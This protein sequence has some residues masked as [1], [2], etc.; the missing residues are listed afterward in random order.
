[1]DFKYPT[2]YDR[3]KPQEMYNRHLGALMDNE[4]GPVSQGKYESV[5]QRIKSYQNN[6]E[7]MAKQIT[8]L[9]E[10]INRELPRIQDSLG[11]EMA[12]NYKGLIPELEK[13][14]PNK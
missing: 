1:M 12:N 2:G 3:S 9:I 11:E 5:I 10:S 13:L 6:P 4:D 8:T 14:L 7:E